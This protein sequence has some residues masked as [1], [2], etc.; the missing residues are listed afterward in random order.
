MS[1]S[2]F[3]EYRALT[4]VAVIVIPGCSNNPIPLKEPSEYSVVVAGDGSSSEVKN[5]PDKTIGGLDPAENYGDLIRSL[6]LYEQSF[7]KT[8][9]EYRTKS[10]TSSDGTALGAVVG[11]VGGFF[12]KSGAIYG[13]AG[14][15]AASSIYSQRYQ[16]DV[17]AHNYRQA[18]DS[19]RCLRNRITPYRAI[20]LAEITE[21]NE[22]I[23][24]T[25]DKLFDAQWS[26][27]LMAPDVDALKLAFER[28]QTAA[29]N[30]RAAEVELALA[31]DEVQRL[32]DEIQM[33]Q[34]EF[35]SLN[36]QIVATDDEGQK[37]LTRSRADL[38]KEKIDT[39]N[40]DKRTA[41]DRVISAR[42]AVPAA[43]K[44]ELMAKLDECVESA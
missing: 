30:K 21:V 27:E 22:K 8:A 4:V 25:V 19:I 28:G 7:K 23:N 38:L 43:E 3:M 36:R 6:K 16:F 10:Y 29:G 34:G 1:R 14:L 12:E 35:E 41:L 15:A 44:N 11:V 9:I 17:Q 13:G 31:E 32:T 20:T 24:K 39:L 2:H 40:E 37:D 5:N 33:S 26:L 18:Y 42:Q